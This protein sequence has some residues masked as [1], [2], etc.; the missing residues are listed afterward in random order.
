MIGS[1]WTLRRIRVQYHI[2]SVVFKVTSF[3]RF[4]FVACSTFGLEGVVFHKAMQVA[5]FLKD[6]QNTRDLQV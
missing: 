4:A 6:S 3:A 5:P 1:P 2:G